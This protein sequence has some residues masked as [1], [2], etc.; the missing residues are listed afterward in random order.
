MAT[1]AAVGLSLSCSPEVAADIFYLDLA[2]RWCEHQLVGN[3]TV[4]CCFPCPFTDW[5]YSDGVS[6]TRTTCEN[7][8]MVTGLGN[9]MVPWLALIVLVFVVIGALTYILLPAEDTRR[10]Y[11]VISPLMGFVFMPVCPNQPYPAITADEFWSAD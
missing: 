4:S 3:E 5:K 6:S 7:I 1:P 11:L 9:E 2:G 8:N 10:H